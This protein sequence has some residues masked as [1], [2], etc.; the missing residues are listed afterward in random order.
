MNSYQIKPEIFF[1][2]IGN[3]EH[4]VKV[5]GSESILL[6]T[7]PS[8]LKI[9]D[10]NGVID[11]LRKTHQLQ[12]FSDLKPNVPLNQL[13]DILRDFNEPDLIIGIGGGSV[14][15]ASKALS[16]S[17]RSGNVRDLFYKKEERSGEKI[18][19]YVVPTT[20]GTGAELSFGA[21]LEDIDIG[22]KGGLRGSDIQPD[23][24]LVD[25]SLYRSVPKK[26]KAEVGFDALTHAIET[27]ISKKS[28][29]LV[30]L[31]SINAIKII[32]EKLPA[33]VEGR[34]RE[35]EL[36]AMTSSL[37]GINLA[38]SSTC[39]PHR[40]QYI[41]GPRT[42]TTHAQGLV[43]LYN[44][45][46][47]LISKEEKFEKLSNDLGFKGP[48]ELTETIF[49]LKES[50]NLNYRL[51]SHGISPQEIDSLALEVDGSV[52]NDPCYQGVQTIKEILLKSL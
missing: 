47:P 12:V 18:L 30:E 37:M 23:L 5:S 24:V 7:S 28:S 32:L 52:E 35:M 48:E 11:S 15:D 1:G 10:Q 45:W 31:N 33:A 38:K 44:G 25:F 49:R 36:V 3:L 2:A 21:I 42:N 50:I 41:V 17:W 4:L 29:P 40:I 20:A 19:N 27:Y 14:I 9:L 43:I 26:M 8:L 46:L 22:K 16:V 6:I 34:E 39:L 51:S 13:E